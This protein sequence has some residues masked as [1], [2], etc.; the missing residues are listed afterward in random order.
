RRSRAWRG[1]A[2][3]PLGVSED[4]DHVLEERVAAGRAVGAL[5]D[6][7]GEEREEVADPRAR[8]GAQRDVVLVAGVDLPG[9]AGVA[10]APGGA[11]L[12]DELGL[13]DAA[14][15]GVA[16]L[17]LG[18]D[19]DGRRLGHDRALSR[20][21]PEDRFAAEADVA[22]GDDRRARALAAHLE[23]ATVDRP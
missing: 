19:G 23:A 8:L 11:G 3:V 22:G 15:G 13:W 14:A 1:E 5:H 6:F 10:A 2:Q 17:G 20:A 4:R 9:D 7:L 16:R 12:V 21:D 18:G